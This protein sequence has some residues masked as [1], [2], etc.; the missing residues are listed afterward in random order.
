[1]APP[2]Q[3]KPQR[4]AKKGDSKTPEVPL[5]PVQAGPALPETLHRGLR[6]D[7]KALGGL[8]K[9]KGGEAA[10]FE[11]AELKGLRTIIMELHTRYIGEE[12]ADEEVRS[13][14]DKGFVINFEM[15]CNE[16]LVFERSID[17]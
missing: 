4:A 9:L 3:G 8:G 12:K 13:I 1:V 6:Q 2:K 14:L 11:N 10:V 17:A 7:P 15:L 16:K 5:L